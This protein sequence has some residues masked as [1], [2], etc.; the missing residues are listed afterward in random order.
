MRNNMSKK[1]SVGHA[2]GPDKKYRYFGQYLIYP[3]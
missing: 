3:V 1:K 2:D